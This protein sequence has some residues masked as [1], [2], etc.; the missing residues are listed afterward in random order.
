MGMYIRFRHPTVSGLTEAYPETSLI[1]LWILRLLVPLGG[2]NNFVRAE[3]F[4]DND[5]ARAIGMEKWLEPERDFVDKK[6]N[7][8]LHQIYLESERR[9]HDSSVSA[10]LARNVARLSSLVGLS[11]TDCRI[12]EFAV[13]LRNE[14][15]LD[16]AADYLGSELSTAKMF[17]VLAT[18]LDIPEHEIR[19]SFSHQGMLARSNIITVDNDLH[20]LSSKLDFM[21]KK[22][23]ERIYSSDSDPINLIR[24][25]VAPASPAQLALKDFEHITPCLAI[26]RPYLKNALASHR[27]GVN[28]F[29]HGKPGTGKSQLAR[30][31]AQELGYE[32]FEVASEDGDGDPV[33]GIKR[34]FALRAAQYFFAN[35][36]TLL[37]FDEADDIFRGS[38]FSPSTAQSNKAWMNRMLEENTTPI[39][40]ISNSIRE[41][42]PAFLRRFDM[43][44]ELPLPSQKQR[45]RLLQTLC[46]DL[47]EE[48]AVARFAA[49]ESLAPAV[50]SKAAAVVRSIR[51]ELGEQKVLDVEG[52]FELLVNNTLEAQSHHIIK[53]NDPKRLPEVY[54]PQFIHSDVD[55]RQIADGLGQSRAGR[56][57][58][59]GPPGTG[60]TAYGHWL[61]ERLDMPL[62]VKHASDLMSMYVGE[63]EKNIAEAFRQA[64]QEGALLLIDEVDSF[65]Q[66]RRS[67]QNSW[68]VTGV[69]EMLTQMESFS[70]VFIAS[71]NLMDGLDQA[72]LRRFDLKIKFD[73]LK[74]EQACELLRR[75]CA[76]LEMPAPQAELLDKLRRMDKVTPGDFAAVLRQCRFRPVTT[77]AM[78]LA[79]LEEECSLKEGGSSTRI[80]FLS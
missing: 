43:V 8:E 73:F 24:D 63:N 52:A 55:L 16:V 76:Q 18:V 32:L 22:F 61:A 72:A 50:I 51:A 19:A 1:R 42:D 48:R 71:T 65:L 44:F 5:L 13:S 75:H 14:N 2:R 64:E 79:A 21:S 28:I 25:R 45:E 15:L 40:W 37:V 78:L 10:C 36:K 27:Q 34:L 74:P 7:I 80:G 39:L 59:Y 57:C 26:L 4:R 58:L 29:L 3:G 30:I 70:G 49:S 62:L 54:D 9:A 47:L 53:R 12:I 68:E 20:C 46:G 11:A 66:D 41:I 56:L 31:L 38:F 33:T 60:K 77:P 6:V 69:N 67:A 17:H 35:S 23:V